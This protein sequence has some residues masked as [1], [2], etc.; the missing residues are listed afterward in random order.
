M[1]AGACA[2]RH[3]RHAHD[4]GRCRDP[5]GGAAGHRRQAGAA[6]P[7]ADR[8]RGVVADRDGAAGGGR[9]GH[10]ARRPGGRARPLVRPLSDRAD[11]DRRRPRGD[12]ARGPADQ[13]G[14]RLGAAGGGA[15][16]SGVHGAHRRTSQGDRPAA[17]RRRRRPHVPPARSG[18]WAPDLARTRRRRAGRRRDRCQGEDLRARTMEVLAIASSPP[19][20]SSSSPRW[21]SRSPP[22]TSAS[23][24]SASSTSGGRS[25]WPAA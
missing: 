5:R 8:L 21:A 2:R 12:P 16:H 23:I 6:A 14:R 13:L 25:G 7:V 18:R 9:R 3:R 24:C 10:H 19:P 22:S 20:S 11:P 15:V 1:A 4:G 17:A